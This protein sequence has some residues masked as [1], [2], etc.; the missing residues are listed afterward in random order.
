[1][2]WLQVANATWIGVGTIG[3]ESVAD[4]PFLVSASK[5]ACSVEHLPGHADPAMGLWIDMGP[6]SGRG[7][8]NVSVSRRIRMGADGQVTTA[9]GG[10]GLYGP[11]GL[12]GLRVGEQA[13][14]RGFSGDALL[15][16]RGSRPEPDRWSL[17]AALCDGESAV[18]G[19]T[20]L[21]ASLTLRADAG[22]AAGLLVALT[23]EGALGD[24]RVDL[25]LSPPV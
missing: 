9:T 19:A 22:R 15:D 5:I 6:N 1:M 13:T 8:G 18:A 25:A 10:V 24:F 14:A 17:A 20:T 3:D 4:E 12:F 2:G 23:V 16:V 21:T 11:L 7:W